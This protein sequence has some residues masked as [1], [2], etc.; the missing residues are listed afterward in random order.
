MDTSEEHI[1][2]HVLLRA[3][4]IAGI[5]VVIGYVFY[6][7]KVF[8]P[9][10]RASQFMVSSITAGLSYALLKS[11]AQRNFWS[12]IFVWYVLLCGVFV[13]FNRWLI[14]LN[15]VYIGGISGAILL[16]TYVVPL[17]YTNNF[18]VRIFFAG[19]IISVANGIII[20][21]LGFFSFGTIMS[22]FSVWWESVLFNLKIGSIIGLGVGAGI[23]IAEYFNGALVEYEE[24]LAEE[25]TADDTDD[26]KAE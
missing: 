4:A 12:V 14:I 19:A 15:A 1:W 10:M 25:E 2:K 7:D 22:H 5:G 11:S 6:G 21:V 16:Y 9:T 17:K 23:E 3:F 13:E 20:V 8:I 18:M 26:E 24:G